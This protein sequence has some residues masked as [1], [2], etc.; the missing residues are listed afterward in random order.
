MDTKTNS[1]TD[2]VKSF[3]DACKVL[4][5][6]HNA[7]LSAIADLPKD[8]QAYRKLK[9]IAEALNEGWKPDW[10]NGQWDKWYPWFDLSSGSGLSLLG[11]DDRYSASGVSSRLCYKSS[12]LAKYAGTHFISLYTDLFVI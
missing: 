7:Q 4:G 9:V 2:Q 8:E 5:I 6:D 11:A 1:I 10:K 3:E 12:N